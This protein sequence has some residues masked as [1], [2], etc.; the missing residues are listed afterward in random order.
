[1]PG[2]G[3]PL[4]PRAAAWRGCAR[5]GDPPEPSRR[6]LATQVPARLRVAF[7]RA[8]RGTEIGVLAPNA[9]ANRVAGVTACRSFNHGLS[10]RLHGAS[11]R[12]EKEAYAVP[13]MLR[14]HRPVHALR[15][16]AGPRQRTYRDGRRPVHLRLDRKARRR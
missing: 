10:L 13:T 7:R 6:R 3:A 11:S 1:R 9:F 15:W 2:H 4:R 8:R 14:R 5:G 12:I 16:A